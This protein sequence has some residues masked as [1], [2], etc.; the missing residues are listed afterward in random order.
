MGGRDQC[1]PMG[2][3]KDWPG[4]PGSSF[5]LETSRTTGPFK[6]TIYSRER[7]PAFQSIFSTEVPGKMVELDLIVS[8]N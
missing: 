6:A 3:G 2:G 8:N 4:L 5:K 7:G 1:R